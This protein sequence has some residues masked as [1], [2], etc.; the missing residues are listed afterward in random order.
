MSR[1]IDDVPHSIA[2]AGRA[3]RP[4]T[5]QRYSPQGGGK[6]VVSRVWRPGLA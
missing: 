3:G 5:R 2:S 6:D 4:R 1:A